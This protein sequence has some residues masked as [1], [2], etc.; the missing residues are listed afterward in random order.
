MSRLARHAAARQPGRTL[1]AVRRWCVESPE[2]AIWA[3]GVLAVIV[4]AIG[5]SR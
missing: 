1:A 5:A 4:F 3:A 2:V